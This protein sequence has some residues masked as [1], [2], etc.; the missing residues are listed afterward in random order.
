MKREHAGDS[1]PASAKGLLDDLL[2]T[3][4]RIF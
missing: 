3:L 2:E 1:A 4:N